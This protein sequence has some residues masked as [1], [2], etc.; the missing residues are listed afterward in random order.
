MADF[1][2]P[3]QTKP[4]GDGWLSYGGGGGGGGGD[5]WLSV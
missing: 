5:E 3:N 2:F 4:W 1:S